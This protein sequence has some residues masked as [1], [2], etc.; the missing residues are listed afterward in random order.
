MMVKD[1]EWPDFTPNTEVKSCELSEGMIGMFARAAQ[2]VDRNEVTTA[3]C[4]SLSFVKP[5][6][7]RAASD[8]LGVMVVSILLKPQ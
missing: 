3:F 5:I 2:T 7:E 6:T 1:V 4:S 8:L